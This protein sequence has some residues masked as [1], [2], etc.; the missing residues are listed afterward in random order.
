MS[1]IEIYTSDMD[2]KKVDALW[3]DHNLDQ[4]IVITIAPGSK[5]FTK[6]WPAEYY[7][8]L[9]K[10]LERHTD[11]KVIVIGSAEDK[12]LNIDMARNTVDL[13]GDTRLLE[14]AEILKRSHVLVSNDSAPIHIASAFSC[15]IIAIFGATTRDLGFFPWSPNSTVIEVD[16]LACRPCGLHGSKRCPKGHF[17]CMLDITPEQVYKTVIEK[18]QIYQ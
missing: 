7:G 12:N 10:L 3:R 2:V 14:V 16:D 15:H 8:Q 1:M 17:K 5:W 6:M 11:I 4:H 9:L 18:V 13:R